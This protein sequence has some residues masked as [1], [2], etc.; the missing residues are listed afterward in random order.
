MTGELTKEQKIQMAEDMIKALRTEAFR[1]ELEKAIHAGD[2]L[3]VNNIT[4]QMARTSNRIIE[5]EKKLAL[6]KL[7]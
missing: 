3:M 5:A 2:V 6:I 7:I 1:L 4:E